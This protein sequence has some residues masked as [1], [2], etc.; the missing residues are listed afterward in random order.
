MF[1]STATRGRGS[2]VESLA[3][4]P[5]GTAPL[6]ITSPVFTNHG[7]LPLQY[8]YEGA[9]ISPSLDIGGLPVATQ[10]L[11]LVMDDLDAPHGH[12]VHWLAWNIPPVKHLPDAR[13][14]EMEGLNDFR[15]NHY[16]GPCPEAGT[17]R[18]VFHCYALD[19][20]LDLPPKTRAPEALHVIKGHIL[21]YGNVTTLYKRK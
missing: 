13:R 1:V 8:T 16:Q 4:L 18:Y 2:S 11:M 10:S 9:G 15:A 17:H 12:F 3:P 7:M 19:T 20:T 14:M 6:T 21:G 5:A